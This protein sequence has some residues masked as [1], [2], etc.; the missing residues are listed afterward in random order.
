MSFDSCKNKSTEELLFE[1]LDKLEQRRMDL[2]EKQ[3]QLFN[4]D[5]DKGNVYNVQH[6]EVYINLQNQIDIID[7]DIDIVKQKLELK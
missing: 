7:N 6:T 5:F 2:F 4:G 3:N 1:R